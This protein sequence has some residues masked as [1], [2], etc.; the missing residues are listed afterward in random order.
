MSDGELVRQV[1]AGR[2]ELYEELVRRWA[3]RVAAVCHARVGQEA[4]VA[5][6]IQET[7][8]RGYR[9]LRTLSDPEKFGPWLCGIAL[10]ASLTWLRQQQRTAASFSDVSPHFDPEA[11]APP[12][13]RQEDL[14]QLMTEVEALPEPYRQV[15]ML[16]YYEDLT[17]RELA[18]VLG[19]A[20]GTVNQR[21]T[22]ARMLL[23]EKMGLLRES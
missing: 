6:L 21:L 16:Y 1:L 3:R 12:S 19:I 22:R 17:Y 2:I 7:L 23:R 8:L 15:V 10:R 13:D 5:D 14:R 4:A 18:H 20:P 9:A 11:I